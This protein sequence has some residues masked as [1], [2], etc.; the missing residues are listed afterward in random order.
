MTQFKG[1]ITALV[2]PF[3]DG[4]VDEKAFRGFINWQIENG[5]HGLVPV[6]TT[7]ES[8]TLSHKEH[9]GVIETCVNEA[10]GRVPVIAGAGSNSTAEAVAF[11]KHAE[12][13]GAD[14]VLIVTPYY[15][16][17]TQEGLYQHFK[18]IN[19][20]IGIPIII[21]NIPGRSVIDMSVDTMARL[22]EL[23]NIVGVK[24]ATANIA[25]VS[26]QRKAMGPDFIQLS[27][28]D[29]TALGFMAHGGHGCISVTANVAPA[30]CAEMQEA[31]MKG[32]YASALKVQDRLMPLHD[33]MF[34]E[35]NP[36]PAKYAA[37]VLGLMGDTVRLPLLPVSEGTKQV[38]RSAMIH[39]G[40]INA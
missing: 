36:S 27:G 1:S 33:A 10:K 28:E 4:A 2:T 31:C 18:A 9:D 29:A 24:D 20:A 15:N 40:L 21:Y 16:K 17:P 19:D 12:K 22:Y 35:T 11:S 30:L 26:Q 34:I 25:R 8:P 13:V 6:G 37:S 3:K 32:D 14:A 7:G 38:L 39:A 23:K 5:T